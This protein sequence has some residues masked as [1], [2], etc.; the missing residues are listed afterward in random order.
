MSWNRDCSALW[1]REDLHEIQ[2]KDPTVWCYNIEVGT[3]SARYPH[4]CEHYYLSATS[5]YRTRLCVR[6]PDGT[7]SADFLRE[8]CAPPSPPPFPSSPVYSPPPTA[9]PPPPRPP[10][11]P[12]KPPLPSPP[13]IPHEPSPPPPVPLEPPSAPSP[14]PPAPPSPIAPPGAPPPL[15]NPI[16][17]AFVASSIGGAM[18]IVGLCALVA[19]RYRARLLRL[20]EKAELA[21]RAE[22][23]GL[24]A[25]EPGADGGGGVGGRLRAI[26][27]R[28]HD[29]WEEGVNHAL[30]SVEGGQHDD[31]DDDDDHEF[32][33]DNDAADEE[34]G[35]FVGD[36]GEYGDGGGGG[37]VV[38]FGAPEPDEA[39][40]D[41]VEFGA[42]AVDLVDIEVPMTAPAD[43]AVAPVLFGA[44]EEP[45]W[46]AAAARRAEL[47]AAEAQ[48]VGNALE[49]GI[50]GARQKAKQYV[51][52]AA[53]LD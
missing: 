39:E 5:T 53:G 2:K 43:A 14:P 16:V 44:P 51:K 29:R 8:D 49:V 20:V 52:L 35:P 15:V 9:P 27:G 32:D 47:E 3:M 25:P 23:L 31:D 30:E 46:D 26:A 24:E 7:C 4:G 6:Q 50:D 37:E 10:P 17:A 45:A 22:E 11:P 21:E 28:L 1:G 12:P 36:G 19:W 13:P 40:L 33:D 38:L 34:E 48:R 41:A 42:P 18:L